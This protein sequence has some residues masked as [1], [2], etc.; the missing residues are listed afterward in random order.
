MKQER[1]VIDA[2]LVDSILS[3]N[4]EKKRQAEKE[5]FNFYYNIYF[6][7]FKNKLNND[8]MAEDLTIDLLTKVFKNINSYNKKFAL[9]T[10]IKKMATN[11]LIDQYRYIHALKRTKNTVSLQN[12]T[13]SNEDCLFDTSSNAQEK[14]EIEEEKNKISLLINKLKPDYKMM[15][16][17]RYFQ[18]MSYE[19]I[20]EE[21]NIPMG[22]VKI[23]IHRAKIDLKKLYN[24]K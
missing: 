16:E 15:L 7:F 18:E 9:S 4:E 20:A 3:N 13:P 23:Y 11:M 8:Y 12:L 24:K 10:W 1:K 2:Q 14:I 17:L 19:E 5:L 6:L 22:T 21:T